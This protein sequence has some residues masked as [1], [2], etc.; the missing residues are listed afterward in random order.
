[1]TEEELYRLLRKNFTGDISSEEEIRLQRWIHESI[2]NQKIAET[3]S[4]VWQ[5]KSA[6][7]E[8]INSEAQIDHIWQRSQ[9]NLQTLQK[10]WSYLLKIAAVI[11][12]FITTPLLV[13]NFMQVSSEAPVPQATTEIIKSNPAG[14]K[15]KFYLPDG[16][17]VWLNG[18]STITYDSKFNE[19]NRNIS[20]QGEA[21]FEVSRNKN[22]P[23]RV[24][25]GKLT[26]TA[27]GTAFNIEAYPDDE[28]KK[29]SLLHGKVKVVVSDDNKKED[30][31]LNPG[32]QI[33]YSS[34]SER[35]E[36]QSFD[37][38]QVVGWKEG[39]L[40]FAGANYQ[41]VTRK[42]EKWY[43]VDITTRG[44]PP[45]GWKLSTTYQDESLRNILKNLRFGKKFNYKLGKDELK[46][47]FQ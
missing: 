18:A 7:P 14:Q 15:A 5:E 2:E 34:I 12:L 41:E 42:L 20:L 16:S 33:R 30:F 39:K 46:I 38:N 8:L 21:Y 29:I 44:N 26:T 6:E 45:A 27:L 10:D 36:K 25:I 9:D 35:S 4:Q 3:L 43:G 19:I 40:V 31:I 37:P 22:L 17:L 28:E 23:F 1:M 24:S 13:I 32:Y 11:V 47:N